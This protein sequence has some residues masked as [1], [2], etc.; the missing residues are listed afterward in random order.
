VLS[1]GLDPVTPP[2]H[3]ERVARALGP[4]TR[5]IVVPNA[6]HGVLGVGCMG[7]LLHRFINASDDTAAIGVDA[8]CATG[9]PRPHSLRP[10][11][12]E[13]AQ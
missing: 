3:G 12:L 8:S 7:D 5:H 9:I 1:G 6:G 2:R 11:T 4:A 13:H 10:L